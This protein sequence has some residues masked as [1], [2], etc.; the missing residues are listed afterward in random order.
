[1]AALLPSWT[2]VIS[3]PPV[4]VI[5]I[6]LV[7]LLVAPSTPVFASLEYAHHSVNARP[8]G[9]ASFLR[10]L[11]RFLNP[12]V[13]LGE[14]EITLL[15]EWPENLDPAPSDS[16]SAECVVCQGEPGEADFAL[17]VPTP[18]CR[19]PRQVCGVCLRHIVFLFITNGD[20]VQGIPCPSSDCSKIMRYHDIQ[21]WSSPGTF[22]R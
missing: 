1:M 10:N 20:C 22:T 8:S 11:W 19:H 21:K 3:Y 17:F 14:I 6:A 12:K 2:T 7:T 15:G 13:P 5:I 18:T 4:I 9:L 16:S